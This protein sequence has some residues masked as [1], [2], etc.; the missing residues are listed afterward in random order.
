MRELAA[1]RSIEYVDGELKAVYLTFMSLGELYK[2]TRVFHY[3]LKGDISGA[4]RMVSEFWV[5]QIREAIA[6]GRR[7]S[8]II[9]LNARRSMEETLTF[10]T[11]NGRVGMVVIPPHRQLSVVDG[12]HRIMAWSKLQGQ[13]PDGGPLCAVLIV[14]GMSIQQE[15]QEFLNLNYKRG[16]VAKSHVLALLMSQMTTL[17]IPGE[18]DQ[19]FRLKSSTHSGRNR[20][21]IPEQIDHPAGCTGWAV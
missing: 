2:G 3:G 5:R 21:P 8:G 11:E 18:F 20:P 9:V 16:K 17:R 7:L 10:R 6:K 4:Q 1:A 12:Q 14:D 19:S 13:F 15:I